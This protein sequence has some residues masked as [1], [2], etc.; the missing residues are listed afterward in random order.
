MLDCKDVYILR[1]KVSQ[2]TAKHAFFSSNHTIGQGSLSR[3]GDLIA[4]LRDPGPDQS[5]AATRIAEK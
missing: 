5:D 1:L 2:Y 4:V 3:A